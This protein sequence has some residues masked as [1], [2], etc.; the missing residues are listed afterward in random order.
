MDRQNLSEIKI[1]VIEVEMISDEKTFTH[2]HTGSL[3][4]L[5]VLDRL[6]NFLEDA[7]FGRHRAFELLDSV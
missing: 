5:G 2:C 4:H 3:D 7:Y 6:V 1:L